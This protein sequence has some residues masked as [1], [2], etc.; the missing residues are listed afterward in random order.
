MVGTR[1]MKPIP[2]PS[3]SKIASLITRRLEIRHD[4][5]GDVFSHL[6][7]HARLAPETQKVS[8]ILGVMRSGGRRSP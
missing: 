1:Q 8:P 6:S 7:D 2:I 5:D 3:R 4:A